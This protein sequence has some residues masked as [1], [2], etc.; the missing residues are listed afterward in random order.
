LD[1]IYL[2]FENLVL[3]LEWS[4]VVPFLLQL[5]GEMFN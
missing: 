3:L 1:V 4:G 2:Q 5:D